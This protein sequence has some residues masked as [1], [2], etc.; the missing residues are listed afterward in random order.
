MADYGRIIHFRR[1]GKF[2]PPAP[3]WAYLV[4]ALLGVGLPLAVALLLRWLLPLP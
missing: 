2:P 3:L 1:T 4:G